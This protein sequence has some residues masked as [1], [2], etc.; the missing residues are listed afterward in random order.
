MQQPSPEGNATSPGRSTQ[1][2]KHISDRSRLALIAALAL[3][4]VNLRPLITALGPVLDSVSASLNL[5]GTAIGMLITLPVL[6]FGAFAPFV[7]RLLRFSS[8][9]RLILYALGV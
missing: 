1:S 9:E 6:C 2:P 8:P 7:P 3:V 4:S 5:S